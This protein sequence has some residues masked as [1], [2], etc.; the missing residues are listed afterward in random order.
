LSQGVAELAISV[1][2]AVLLVLVIV[3]DRQTHRGC[4][5]AHAQRGGNADP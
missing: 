4:V 1:V 5:M 3:V 2:T